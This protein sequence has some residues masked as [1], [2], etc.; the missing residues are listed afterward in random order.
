LNAL[1]PKIA[2][3]PAPKISR[4]FGHARLLPVS[5]FSRRRSRQQDDLAA[6]P[7]TEF[8]GRMDFSR[9]RQIFVGGEYTVRAYFPL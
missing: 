8:T 9:Q 7:G 1:N 5:G 6:N 3:S 2:I 4:I